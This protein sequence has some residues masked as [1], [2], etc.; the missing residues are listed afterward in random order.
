MA[1]VSGQQFVSWVCAN[2][3]STSSLV[4]NIFS[5]TL[6]SFLAF[7]FKC[8]SIAPY[9]ICFFPSPNPITW[10]IHQFC[11]NPPQ[12]WPAAAHSITAQYWSFTSHEWPKQNF[13]LPYQYNIN[14]ITNENKEKYKIED[15]LPGPVRTKLSE[16]ASLELCGRQ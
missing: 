4:A 9:P 5:A 11:F 12:F 1:G 15:F 10:P 2:M 14:Q 8:S 6:C 3:K 16:Q 13:S 7:D